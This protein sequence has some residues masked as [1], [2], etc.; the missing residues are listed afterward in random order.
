ML[1]LGQPPIGTWNYRSTVAHRAKWSVPYNPHGYSAA[2]RANKYLH[3]WSVLCTLE[4][5]CEPTKL[6]VTAICWI[7]PT[8]TTKFLPENNCFKFSSLMQPFHRSAASSV[9]SGSGCVCPELKCFALFYVSFQPGCPSQRVSCQTQQR[10][11]EHLLSLLNS[12]QWVYQNEIPFRSYVWLSSHCLSS[13]S[14]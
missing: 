10:Y 9:Q 7:R 4:L 14:N 11:T 5:Y 8:Q 3:A 6:W 12:P 1:I 13:K 2:H